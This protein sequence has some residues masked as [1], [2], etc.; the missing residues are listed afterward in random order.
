MNCSYCNSV[1]RNDDR[2]CPSCGA[3]VPLSDSIPSPSPYYTVTV[4]VD[5]DSETILNPVAA[6]GSS[7][8]TR[9]T[10]SLEGLGKTFQDRS[11]WAMVSLVL[12]IIS[13]FTSI[14]PG[15]CALATSIPAIIIGAMSL[16]SSKRSAA[17]TG[18][19]L[20]VLSIILA[21]V[22]I[23]LFTFGSFWVG[24]FFSGQ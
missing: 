18:I 24:D 20:G 13:T 9:S 6:K 5:P 8:I 14:I 16:K 22:M 12:G 19:F 3:P 21:G 1:I 23:A 2:N 4:V 11:N 17:M 15:G 10:L 7:P